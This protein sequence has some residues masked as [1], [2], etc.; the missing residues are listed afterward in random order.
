[1]TPIEIRAQYLFE[2]LSG[3][4]LYHHSA[5]R[6]GYITRDEIN[7]ISLYNGR[8][9]KGYIVKVPYVYDNSAHRSKRYYTIRYYIY[10]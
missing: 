7:V 1:M 5:K 2:H 9:G 10:A 3:K 4:L 6:R 8:F